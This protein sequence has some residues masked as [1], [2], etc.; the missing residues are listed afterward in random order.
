MI[1]IIYLINVTT[2]WA[3]RTLLHVNPVFP[4]TWITKFAVEFNS[5][6]VHAMLW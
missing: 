4:F 2:E 3:E 5:N 1:L 6:A